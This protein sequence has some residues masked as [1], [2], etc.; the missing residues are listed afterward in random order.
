MTEIVSHMREFYRR[1]LDPQEMVQV[2]V[3]Q[4][5]QDV[6]ELTR[7]RWRDLAQREGPSIT[8]KCELEAPAPRLVCNAAEL[9]EALTNLIFNA[10][11]ALP[12]GGAIILATRS[13]TRPDSPGGATAR[14]DLLVEVRD[15][16]IGHGRKSPPALSGTVFL[17]QGAARRNGPGTGHGLWHGATPQRAALK[18]KARRARGLACA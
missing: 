12:H 16:G 15:N 4:A 1:D 5:I 6:I 7:P 8:V 2:N 13:V 9:R 3:N 18:L 10:V 11:D 17:H 14:Q